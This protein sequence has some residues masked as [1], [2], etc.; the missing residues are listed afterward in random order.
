[1]DI[2]AVAGDLSSAKHSVGEPGPRAPGGI[3]RGAKVRSKSCRGPCVCKLFRKVCRLKTLNGDPIY[4]PSS[5]VGEEEKK[6]V[7][8]DRSPNRATKLILLQLTALLAGLVLKESIGVERIVSEEL[9]K[10]PVEVIATGFR[11]DVYVGAGVLAIAGIILASLDLEL[12]KSVGAGNRN[13]PKRRRRVLWGIL[14]YIRHIDAIHLEIITGVATPVNVD[15]FRTSPK[16]GCVVD[17]RHDSG[18]QTQN[19]CVIAG[20]QRKVREKLVSNHITQSDRRRLDG[21]GS[22]GHSDLL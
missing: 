8:P 16:R 21:L 9:E 2:G 7:P 15:V 11:N 18:R 14:E 22:R 4:L 19:L 5:L 6:F 10:R 17:I 12:L 20:D 3:I 1:I 13:R